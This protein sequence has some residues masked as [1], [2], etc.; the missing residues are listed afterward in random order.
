MKPM[1]Q[2]A[3]TSSP[4]P[5][6]QNAPGRVPTPAPAQK[7]TPSSV[8][9][10]LE[11]ILVAFILAFIFRAFVVEAF[12][13]PTGSMAP[14]LLGAHMR[15]TCPDCGY[16]FDVN[17]SPAPSG[18]DDLYIPSQ[19]R[20]SYRV[21]CP[22]CGFK[23]PENDVAQPP[24]H[25]GD[26]ILVLK[27]LY[28][29]RDPQRWDV[30]VFKSPDVKSPNDFDYNPNTPTYQ[31]NYIKRLIGK[32]NESVM[33]LDGDIYIG[34]PGQ[35][36]EQYTIQTKPRYAQEALWRV[37]YDND[38][39]P[40]SLTRADGSQWKQPWTVAEGTGWKVDGPAGGRVFEFDNAGGSSTLFFDRTA[41]PVFD[42]QLKPWP[43]A[44]TDWLA[45]D[46]ETDPQPTSVYLNFAQM[47]MV[48]DVKLRFAY[49]RRSGD[50]PLRVRLTSGDDAFIAV[51]T[52]TDA[53]LY[54][55]T[56]DE[57]RAVGSPMPMP[58]GNDPVM[59]E[60]TN[61]D[62]QVALRINEKVAA[63][64]TPDEYHPNVAAL[65]NADAHASLRPVPKIEIEAAN[66]TASLSHIGLWR[67][68]FYIN[69]GPRVDF[70][71]PRNIMHLGEDEY[72]VLGDNSLIS[73]DA[74]YWH[75]PI[76][77]PADRLD[78]AAARV[79]GRFMLGRAFFVYWPAGFRPGIPVG[80][81]PNFGDMRF[82]R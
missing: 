44:F 69:R 65:L 68:I 23:L 60:L 35:K 55:K 71:T 58:K 36:P 1:T 9:E 54:H 22:N 52:P 50:G 7:D 13:I 34:Q 15:F 79:P 80:I 29:F 30:V 31:Q 39:H 24:V 18:T 66:Q 32:P 43:Y 2:P 33:I 41:V 12:V 59:V 49:T 78:V 76:H 21:F 47:N 5:A 63:I 38:Y 4:P 28:L 81:A 27:Y 19:S 6:P 48:R 16:G 11:S 53:R 42:R 56:G 74:R 25:Y 73:G 77:L 26:R 82:I 75:V 64:T 3:A 62:Y 37:I 67:D 51:I 14:T 10:T 45:Y 61:A 8:K 70:G 72:F 46:A 57:E 17:Y 20:E 40:L